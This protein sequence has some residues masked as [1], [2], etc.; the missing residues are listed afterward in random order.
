M[1]FTKRKP[2]KDDSSA[3]AYFLREGIEVCLVLGG[4]AI[5]EWFTRVSPWLWILLPAGKLLVSVI[6]YFLFVKKILRKASHHGAQSL[7]GQNARTLVPL[8]PVG[9]IKIGSEIWAARSRNNESIAPGQDVAICEI[10]GKF[11]LVEE[12]QKGI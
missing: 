5:A 10:S 9:Q 12:V 11:L 6:F 2:T 4:L 8:D 1:D 3:R 7:I